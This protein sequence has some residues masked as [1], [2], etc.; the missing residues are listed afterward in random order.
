MAGVAV[1]AHK[2]YPIDGSIANL[3]VLNGTN[4]TAEYKLGETVKASDGSEFVYVHASG[5]LTIYDCVGIDE[6]Y[7]AAAITKAMADDG[8]R[9]GF[10]QIAFVDNDYGWVAVRG[11]GDNFKCNVLGSCAA[12]VVLYTSAT[13][14]ALDDASSSQTKID[15]V[16]IITANASSGLASE[17]CIATFP[18]STTF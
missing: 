18:K 1:V 4:D 9:V 16:V 6:N 12:D 17:L 13:A 10:A 8:F 3:D 7:E 2:H 14:G 15:G 11:H 5:A